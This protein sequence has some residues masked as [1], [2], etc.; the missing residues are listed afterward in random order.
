MA[1][2]G[3]EPLQCNEGRWDFTLREAEDDS[4]VLLEVAVGQFLDTSLINVD[5][6]PL[7]VRLLIKVLPPAQRRH[8]P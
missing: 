7:L 8:W 4:A 3:K 1:Q 6:Q 2:E 5:V